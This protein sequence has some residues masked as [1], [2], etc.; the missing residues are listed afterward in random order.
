MGAEHPQTPAGE[1]E[2]PRGQGPELGP[3]GA[4]RRACPPLTRG[5]A[6]TA[7]A[8]AQEGPVVLSALLLRLGWCPPFSS[9]SQA[10]DAEKA[11]SLPLPCLGRLLRRVELGGCIKK[12]ERKS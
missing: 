12:R 6:L 9:I 4:Q 8:C 1:G 11:Q 2:Y 5:A 7:L 3:W 10:W